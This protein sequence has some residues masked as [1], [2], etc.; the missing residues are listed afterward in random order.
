MFEA[1]K[2]GVTIALTNHVSK[3]LL[4]MRRDFQ[5]TDAQAKK[6]QAT[7]HGIERTALKG[8]LGVGLGYGLLKPLQAGY[9]AAKK[10]EQAFAAFKSLNLGDGINSQADKFAKG[11]N[12]IG[13]SATD[14]MQISR[15]LTV[16]LGDK[17][18]GMVQQLAPGF[19]QLK[20]ANQA[21]F[22]GHGLNFDERQMRDFERIVEMKGGFKSAAD[23]LGQAGMLQQAVAATGGLVMPA[24]FIAF[25]KTAGVSGRLLNNKAFY[26]GMEPLIQEMGGSRVGTGMQTGYNQWAMG[27]LPQAAAEEMVRLGLFDTKKIEYSKIGTIKRV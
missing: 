18:Q 26:Y 12:I 6:L 20:F 2:V 14:L 5:G 25:I 19:A 27:H 8:A 21:V 22:G 17:G 13:A 9:Q 4:G 16:V 3:A 15:D 7:M 11:A 23:F 1:Y 24:D 10:Y